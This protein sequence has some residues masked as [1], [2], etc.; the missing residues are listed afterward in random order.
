M[1]RTAYDMI[2]DDMASR[3]WAVGDAFTMADCAAGPPLF[4]ANKLV[5]F[6]D[7]HRHVTGYFERLTKRPCFARALAEAA[8]YMKFFPG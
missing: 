7:S 4:F 5:P 8:P 3:T 6:G 1:L 2:E